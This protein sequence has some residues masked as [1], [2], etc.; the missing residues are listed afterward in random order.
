[1]KAL[2]V[3]PA[4]LI[5]M[6]AAAECPVKRPTQAPEMPVVSSA[7][8]A[9]ML[10]AQ[11]ATQAYVD[12]VVDFLNCREYSIHDVEYNYFVGA[13]HSAADKYNETLREFKQRDALASS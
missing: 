11:T 6:N 1:M 3:V 12:S 5:A 10:A 2:L 13:A 4:M 8:K 7:S 9:E